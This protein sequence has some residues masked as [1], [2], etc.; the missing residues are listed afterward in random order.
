MLCTDGEKVFYFLVNIQIKT[1]PR[2][3]LKCESGG[4]NALAECKLLKKE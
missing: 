3:L 4:A 2:S 1:K